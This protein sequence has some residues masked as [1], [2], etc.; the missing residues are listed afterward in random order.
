[1]ESYS[2][3]SFLSSQNLGFSQEKIESQTKLHFP[4]HSGSPT[5]PSAAAPCEGTELVK[6][7]RAGP[8][9][10][11][12]GP[13]GLGGAQESASLASAQGHADAAGPGATL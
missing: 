10:R 13:A 7:Q 8:A 12:P 2:R 1:M 4:L 6:A 5:W 9:P 11:L 3:Y